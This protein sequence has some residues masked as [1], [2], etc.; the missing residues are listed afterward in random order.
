MEHFKD[1]SKITMQNPMYSFSR[2][3]RFNPIT[4]EKIGS[5]TSYGFEDYNEGK[6]QSYKANNFTRVERGNYQK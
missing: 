1:A 4:G 5:C 6:N 2:R 3:Q